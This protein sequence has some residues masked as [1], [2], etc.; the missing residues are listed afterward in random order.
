MCVVFYSVAGAFS[1][2][3]SKQLNASISQAFS[4][5]YDIIL[6]LPIRDEDPD[7]G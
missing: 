3:N 6:R 7:L 1:L 5:W 4:W 2:T